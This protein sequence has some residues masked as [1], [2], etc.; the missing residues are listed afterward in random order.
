MVAEVDMDQHQIDDYI[1]L[2]LETTHAGELDL[3]KVKIVVDASRGPIAEVLKRIFLKINV[4][5]FPVNFEGD[6]RLVE[7]FPDIPGP[8]S[9]H[10]L[11]AKLLELGADMGFAFDPNGERVAVMDNLGRVI[12]AEY[13]LQLLLQVTDTAHDPHI[14]GDGHG[15]FYFKELGEAPMAILA[16]LR[17]ITSFSQNFNPLS[18]IIDHIK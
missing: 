3:G 17:I 8:E 9:F 14:A 4:N 1:N 16:M 12:P 15:R 6:P 13:T 10:D 2:L 5:A 11:R 7:V 18:K